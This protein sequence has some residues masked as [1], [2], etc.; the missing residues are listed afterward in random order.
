GIN[1]RYRIFSRSTG[2]RKKA[3]S[4]GKLLLQTQLSH[5]H[6]LHKNIGAFARKKCSR[7]LKVRNRKKSRKPAFN[8]Q[9]SSRSWL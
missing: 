3:I 9:K 1:L 7:D 6:I 8:E 5:S 4:W 2:L